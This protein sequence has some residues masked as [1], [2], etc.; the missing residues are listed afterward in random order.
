MTAPFAVYVRVSEVGDREGPSFGSPEEQ[1]VA[2]REWAERAEIE[3]YF[4]EAEC[5]LTRRV[6]MIDQTIGITLHEAKQINEYGQRVA[7]N[8]ARRSHRR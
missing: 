5:R 8:C 6:V 4:N 3:I 1:E 2:A 7:G